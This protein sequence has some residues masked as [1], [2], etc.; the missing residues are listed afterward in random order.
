MMYCVIL[1]VVVY[2]WCTILCLIYWVI[3]EVVVYMLYMGM[4]LDRGVYTW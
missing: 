4:I 3:V 1:D 2:V